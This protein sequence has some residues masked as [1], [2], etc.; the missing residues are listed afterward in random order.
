MGEY[1]ANHT[2]TAHQSC[3]VDNA[4]AWLMTKTEITDV[5][6]FGKDAIPLYKY[7]Y[8]VIVVKTCT[9]TV[10]RHCR[11]V[12]GGSTVGI[13]CGFSVTPTETRDQR[14]EGQAGV[15]CLYHPSVYSYLWLV[16]LKTGHVGVSAHMS[17]RE[18]IS[19]I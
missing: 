18:I 5:K 8:C 10:I 2:S 4:W 16:Y 1:T 7:G 11:C 19:G 14:R 13:S 15:T 6:Y 3:R 17:G 12:L 9:N